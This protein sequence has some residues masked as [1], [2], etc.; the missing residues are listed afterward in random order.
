[1]AL[2]ND[3]SRSVALR[4]MTCGASYAFE[5]DEETGV[6]T[7]R[8]CNRVYRGGEEELIRLN[9]ALIE[10]E[11]ELL[12]KEVQKDVE[13]EFQKMFKNFKIKL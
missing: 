5:T 11:K 9:E 10:D 12:I 13:N 2:K 7:C 6:V 8:K 4:C 3:Y 1:M